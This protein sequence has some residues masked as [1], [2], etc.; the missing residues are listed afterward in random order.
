MIASADRQ[1]GLVRLIDRAP[2]L[3]WAV[4]ALAFYLLGT[5]IGPLGHGWGTRLMYQH[6]LKAIVG[7]EIPVTR[8]EI[9][10]R[11]Q[12]LLDTAVRAIGRGQTP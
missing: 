1:P 5:S 8:Q 12:P 2:W 3:P 6:Y 11:G 7:I 10:A 9:D 4:G